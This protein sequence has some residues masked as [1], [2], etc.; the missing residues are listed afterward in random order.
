MAT[1]FQSLTA[2]GQPASAQARKKHLVEFRAG[3]LTRA[4]GNWVRPDPRKGQV[5]MDVGD[6]SLLHFC[7]KDRATNRVEDD[8]IIFPEEAEFSRVTQ[9]NDRVF[10]LAFKSSSQKHFFWMQEPKDDKDDDIVKRVNKAIDDP[11]SL[12]QE[13]AGPASPTA[14]AAAAEQAQLLQML[15]QMGTG[16]SVSQRPTSPSRA[17]AAAPRAASPS[18]S[19]TRGAAASAGPTVATPTQQQMDQLR[20]I[21]AG[22]Q[23]PTQQQQQQPDASLSS[24]LS[25]DTLRPILQ[26][27]QARAALFPHLPA[28]AAHSEAELDATI[29]SP[30]FKQ[31][32]QTLAYAV[33]SGAIGAI[34]QSMGLDAAAAAGSAQGGVEALVRAVGAAAKKKEEQ[35]QQDEDRMDTD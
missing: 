23:V 32:V 31:A 21:L 12:Q 3:K 35:E 1:V 33:R 18:R 34:L 15:Q 29:R 16:S 11:S 7:W 20:S 8:L 24:I 28:N 19:P 14:S 27:P 6:D 9:S 4:E 22:I 30:Q 25:I 17:S 13:Q 5:Y 2:Q 10:V 26:D